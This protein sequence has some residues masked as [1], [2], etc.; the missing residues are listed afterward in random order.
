M[1]ATGW[2]TGPHL[3]FEVR[4]NDEAVDAMQFY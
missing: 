3:H 4:I 1:G 2:V